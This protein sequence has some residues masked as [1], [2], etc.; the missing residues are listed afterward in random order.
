MDAARRHFDEINVGDSTVNICS[1]GNNVGVNLI[2]T[3]DSSLPVSG[4]SINYASDTDQTG[5]PASLLTNQ[6]V[7]VEIELPS[8]KST[9]PRRGFGP[10]AGQLPNIAAPLS[11]NVS[12]TYHTGPRRHRELCH[13]HARLL[14][15]VR[16]A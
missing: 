15:P 10:V 14:L 12:P 5:Y 6:Q 11:W 13:Y 16:R 2:V 8:S 4:Q 9:T 1:T 7:G 3:R